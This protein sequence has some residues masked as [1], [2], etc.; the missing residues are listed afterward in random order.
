MHQALPSRGLTRRVLGAAAVLALASACGKP[1]PSP[2]FTVAAAASLTT[3]M[4]EA[5]AVWNAGPHPRG[6]ATYASSSTLARQI[7]RGAPIDLFLSADLQWMNYLET[8]RD[9]DAPSRRVLARNRLVLVQPRADEALHV[10]L[11]PGAAPAAL[12]RGRWTTGDPG[13]VPAGRYAQQALGELGWWQDLAPNL[14]PA[15]D[16]RAALR[17]VERREVEWGLVYLTDAQV[18][19]SVRVVAQ[20]P[21]SIAGPIV[22]VG[23]LTTS[24]NAEVNAD[25]REFLGWLSGPEG[26][27]LFARHGFQPP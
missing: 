17:L 1:Q 3:V 12:T 9:I 15:K 23:A 6:S 13:H 22:T 25:A 8:R 24:A 11:S 21:S 16:V 5:L 10:S 20:V 7:E 2:G 14:I 19:E 4:D 27:A 26:Q 18:S